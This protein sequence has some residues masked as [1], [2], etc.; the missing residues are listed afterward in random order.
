M[1]QLHNSTPFAAN[2]ALFPNEEGIDTLY[3]LVRATFNI[4]K[5]WTLSDEQPQPVEADEYWTEP[6]KSSIKYASDYH[7][8]KA[9]SDIIMLGHA[10]APDG[11]EVH[12]LDVNLV[13]G[14]VRKTVRVFGDRKW[15][16]GRI[17]SPQLFRTMAM[18]YEK[19]YGGV[20]IVD[21]EVDSIEARNPVGRGFAGQRKAEEMDGVPLPNL[22]NPS[23]LIVSSKQ[24]PGPACFGISAPHWLP[25]STYAGTYDDKWQ[26]QRAPYLPTDF[27]K[28]FLSMAHPDLVFPGFI[29]GGEPVEITNMHPGGDIKFNIPSINLNTD[30]SIGIESV[31]R[32]FNL[33]TLIIEPNQLKLSMIW[34]AGIEC[35]KKTLKIGDVKINMVR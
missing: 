31:R 8:G 1:L 21:G 17:S 7:T 22:E 11:K 3:V 12:Q 23:D 19:A 34:R 25:R 26:V 33:E 5:E 13:L 6:G 14:P 27:D 29:E 32:N 10:F 30:V 9:C 28:R 18:V 4:G 35:D 20:H 15:Q 2:I 16:D 24:Q